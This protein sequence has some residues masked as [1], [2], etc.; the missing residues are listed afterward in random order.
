MSNP[1]PPHASDA[2]PQTKALSNLSGQHVRLLG[3]D[4]G[5]TTTAVQ[6]W[7]A[8][9]HIDPLTARVSLEPV[10]AP[11]TQPP[12]FTPFHGTHLELAA[13]Q[14]YLDPWLPASSDAGPPFPMA[15]PPPALE[16]PLLGGGVLITGL[17]AQQQNVSAL[18][19][20]LRSRLQH[21]VIAVADDPGLE[22]WVAFMGAVGTQSLQSAL[23]ILNLDIGGGTTN[24][25][26][27]LGGEVLTTGCAFLGARQLIVDP[28]SLRLLRLS[29]YGMLMCEYL[30]TVPGLGDHLS[31][32]YLEA[33]ANLQV[34]LLELLCLDPEARAQTDPA[35]LTLLD[36]LE[37]VP[38]RPNQLELLRSAAL[39]FSGGVG[40]LLAQVLKDEP[41]PMPL[42]YGDLGVL[43]ARA[44][45]DSPLRSRAILPV[46]APGRATLTGLTLHGA[47]VSG[48][49]VFVS[50]R[51]TLP[52]EDIP[53][54]GTVDASCTLERLLHVLRQVRCC[55]E[56]AGLQI[57]VHSGTP[58][59]V[60]ALGQRLRE[61]L[62]QAAVPLALPLVLLLEKNVGK[63]L[64][65]LIAGFG[66][67]ARALVVVDELV[68]RH[69]RFVRVGAPVK[70]VLPVSF[71][72]L[73]PVPG[74]EAFASE[75]L[76]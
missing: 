50:E 47:Q 10:G 11:V 37:Q 70:G 67:H 49:T 15:G 68:L 66:P 24:L 17:A 19:T 25:A 53:I 35:L 34:R 23:P 71:F 60:L 7:D 38:F 51:V 63:L 32:P 45:A 12:C 3:I 9:L 57:R 6:R 62:D 40:A 5:S 20:W 16:P 26:L 54:L 48:A 64:G 1:C 2:R 73:Q 21:A 65:A 61:G 55:E 29:P 30:G 46:G 58:G 42:A 28:E 76:S 69:A 31:I 14:A 75:S 72:L 36:K 39:S 18:R 43:L 22:S 59:E 33:L 8:L 52:L 56:G 13:L 4:I 27:G 44:L 74:V 41:L